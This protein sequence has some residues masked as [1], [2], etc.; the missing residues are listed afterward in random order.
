[1]CGVERV[2]EIILDYDILDDVMMDFC[3]LDIVS[4]FYINF[5]RKLYSGI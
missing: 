5:E 3:S 4:V 1:M 2:W